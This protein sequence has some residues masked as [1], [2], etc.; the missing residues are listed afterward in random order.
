MPLGVEVTAGG[1]VKT[2]DTR[3][4]IMSRPQVGE[5][6]VGNQQ[7]VLSAVPRTIQTRYTDTLLCVYFLLRCHTQ[8]V[9]PLFGVT[10]CNIR[11]QAEWWHKVGCQRNE[12]S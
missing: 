1:E 11:D 8:G 3:S 10:Y 7:Q 2:F 9:F 4:F 12:F 5:S 6:P